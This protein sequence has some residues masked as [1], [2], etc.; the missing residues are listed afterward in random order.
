TKTPTRSE[1]VTV[2]AAKA[3]LKQA[4]VQAEHS[5]DVWTSAAAQQSYTTLNERGVAET[6]L[7]RGDVFADVGAAYALLPDFG[8]F[9]GPRKPSLTFESFF[10][11]FVCTYIEK[12]QQG[13]IPALLNLTNQ[14]LGLAPAFAGRYAP[15]ARY[16]E[17]PYPVDGV[18]FG[19][20]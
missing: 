12:L 20:T 15:D 18:D 6:L 7:A 16:V 3:Y 13:S 5:A 19:A 8:T 10:H 9:T 4:T 14:Q 1:M 2:T 17:Q 11:P